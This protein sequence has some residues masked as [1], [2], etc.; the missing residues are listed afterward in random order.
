MNSKD[1]SRSAVAQP[2]SAGSVDEV[3]STLSSEADS[4]V[5]LL[6]DASMD[7]ALVE[8]DAVAVSE[9]NNAYDETTF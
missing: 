6:A 3:L 9:L 7:L 2:E 5:N 1:A 8:G 4:G